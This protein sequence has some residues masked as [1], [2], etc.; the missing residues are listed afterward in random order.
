MAEAYEVFLDSS[1]NYTVVFDQKLELQSLP[2]VDDMT[3]TDS[4]I[5]RD[6]EAMALS[7]GQG[8]NVEKFVTQYIADKTKHGSIKNLLS[9]LVN[10][11]D[12]A[13]LRFTP[14]G[15][16]FFQGSCVPDA[17]LATILQSLVNKKQKLIVTGEYCLLMCLRDAP[18]YLKAMILP[19]KLKMCNIHLKEPVQPKNYPLK[20]PRALQESGG[21]IRSNTRL[22]VVGPA[23]YP[24]PRQPKYVQRNP[25][26]DKSK[27]E[28]SK[29]KK[30][31]NVYHTEQKKPWYTLH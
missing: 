22:R 19:S 1:D 20:P 30:Q 18:D 5:N 6:A 15:Q 17:H 4:N 14:D 29:L 16:V 11:I 31:L 3:S 24:L 12:S 21:P 13:T 10:S 7:V 9:Y 23:P 26:L 2:L 27:Q 25:P 8:L 28:V